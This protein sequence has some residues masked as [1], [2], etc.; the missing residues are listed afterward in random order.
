[1]IPREFVY[2]IEDETLGIPPQTLGASLGES[3]PGLQSSFDSPIQPQTVQS[4]NIIVPLIIP[5]GGHV[6]SGQT[7]YDTGTGFFLGDDGGTAKFSLGVGGSTSNNVTFDGTT[8]TVNGYV[9]QKVGTFGGD[10]SDGALSITSGTTNINASSAEV[11]IRNYTSISITSTGALG[12]TNPATNGTL[13]VLKSQ[14]NVTLTSTATQLIDL[15]SDGAAGG[16]VAGPGAAAD[17]NPGSD[18][19]LYIDTSDH[20]GAAGLSTGAAAGGVAAGQ[21]AFYTSRTNDLVRKYV[22]L[23]PGSGGGSGRVND[24]VGTSGVGGRGGGGLLIESAGALNFSGTIN[25]NAAAGG[26]GTASDQTGGGGGGGGG[27]VVIIYETLT[28][29]TGTI[30]KV[31]GAGGSSG[32]TTTGN[33]GGGGGASVS[34]GGAGGSTSASAIAGTAGFGTN[35]GAGGS[36]GGL[37]GGGGGA[38]GSHLII[39]NTA[40]T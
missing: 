16:A 14:G 20:F 24:G 30:N 11:V 2:D 7:A 5:T 37:N 40:F 23:I 39:Q 18:S 8:L 4:G 9:V 3:S 34:A 12:L 6:R 15:S 27:M 29:N 38:G 21:Q 13:L 10:G 26:N 33:G 32:N 22:A 28:A 1:M 25:V 31:G 17:G 19:S 36:G 35:T